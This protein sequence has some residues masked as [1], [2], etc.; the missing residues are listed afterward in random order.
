MHNRN[1]IIPFK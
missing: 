1:S